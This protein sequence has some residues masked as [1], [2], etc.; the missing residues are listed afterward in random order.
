MR[1]TRKQLRGKEAQLRYDRAKK[2]KLFN[3]IMQDWKPPK[4]EKLKW[5]HRTK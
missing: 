2:S 1:Q 3:Q 5:N 4:L